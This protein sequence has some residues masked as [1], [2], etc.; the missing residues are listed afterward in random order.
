MKHYKNKSIQETGS[1][2]MDR[3]SHNFH[4]RK[5]KAKQTKNTSLADD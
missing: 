2:N 1:Q 3:Y 4:T 5:N